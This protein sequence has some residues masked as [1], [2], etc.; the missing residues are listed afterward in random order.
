MMSSLCFSALIL[1]VALR[2]WRVREL[3]D[4]IRNILICVSKMNKCFTGL[5]GHE[6]EELMTMFG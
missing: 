1:S 5:E 4:V 2:L 3:W 6:D